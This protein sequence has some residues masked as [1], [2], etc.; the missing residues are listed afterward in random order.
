MFIICINI[1]KIIVL[2]VYLKLK[3]GSVVPSCVGFSSQVLAE[4]IDCGRKNYASLIN[5]KPD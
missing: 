1:R 4:I 5:T 3:V 2:I